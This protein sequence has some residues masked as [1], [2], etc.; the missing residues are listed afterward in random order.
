MRHCNE[1]I[2]KEHVVEL[3]GTQ[4]VNQ[5]SKHQRESSWAA[6]SRNLAWRR[7]NPEAMQR[8]DNGVTKWQMWE[9]SM[10]EYRARMLGEYV[11]VS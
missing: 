9:A 7:L 6:R 3:H 5:A 10:A 1:R 8:V 11:R 4:D 2:E